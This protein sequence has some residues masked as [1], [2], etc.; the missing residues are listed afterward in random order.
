[1]TTTLPEHTDA[2]VKHAVLIDDALH[3]ER[4]EVLID[5]RV[6]SRC[7]WLWN[8]N[9]AGHVALLEVF[10]E[11]A[12]RRRGYAQRA[13]REAIRRAAAVTTARKVPLRRVT[14]EVEQKA[15]IHARALLTRLGFHHTATSSNVLK[16][17][18]LMTYQI[19]AD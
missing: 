19:A 15:Q 11:P 17:Q 9:D 12:Q 16:D 13:V 4:T 10:T 6:A 3:V 18:D 2:S 5:G 8:G 1:M 7:T 14:I